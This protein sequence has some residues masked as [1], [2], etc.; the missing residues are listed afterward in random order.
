MRVERVDELGT[1]CCGTYCNSPFLIQFPFFF[2]R[3]YL[4]GL[5]TD[6]YGSSTR[7]VVDD[8]NKLLA[9]VFF[10]LCVCWGGVLGSAPC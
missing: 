5:R 3:L 10:F 9:S 4:L 8:V 2:S 7:V 1:P 6:W